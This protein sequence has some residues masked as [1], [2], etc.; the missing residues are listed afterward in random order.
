MATTVAHVCDENLP[1]ALDLLAERDLAALLVE[2]VVPLD[3]AVE[4]ALDADGRGC[5]ARASSS[6]TLQVTA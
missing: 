5:G 2:R 4:D 3:R 1:A 6:S